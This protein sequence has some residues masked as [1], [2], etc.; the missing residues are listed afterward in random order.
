[1]LLYLGCLKQKHPLNITLHKQNAF[2]IWHM[3]AHTF[4][5]HV[6]GVKKEDFDWT[7]NG[8]LMV[9]WPGR[10]D[11]HSLSIMECRHLNFDID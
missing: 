2:F 11:I 6:E 7:I 4:V 5:S 10:I 8:K 1:M 3:M 9:E